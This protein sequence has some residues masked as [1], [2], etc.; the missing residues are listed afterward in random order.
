MSTIPSTSFTRFLRLSI[1]PWQ[2]SRRPPQARQFRSPY[3]VWLYRRLL[4]SGYTPSGASAGAHLHGLTTVR[5][6]TRG[7]ATPVPQRPWLDFGRGHQFG[8]PVRGLQAPG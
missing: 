5:E 1:G 2:V 3:P 7:A 8:D 4:E 6:K